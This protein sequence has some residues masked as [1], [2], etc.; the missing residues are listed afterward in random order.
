MS[1]LVIELQS[2]ITSPGCDIVNILRK[3]HLI[4][5]K[6]HLI[7]F[8]QWISYELNGY[9]N[10]KIIPS[11]RLVCGVLKALNPYR[12]WIP[13]MIS[14]PELEKSICEKKVPNSIS[15]IIDLCEQANTGLIFE[16]SGEQLEF[17]NKLFDAPLPMQYS[18][19]VPSSRVKDIVE[20]VKNTVLE[21]TI[22]LES[23][24]ILGEGMKFNDTEKK[25]AQHIPQTVNNYYGTTSVVNGS[26]QNMQIVSGSDDE[27]T[28]TY[29]KAKDAVEEI[30][31][32]ISND[33]ISDD[34]QKTALE[35]LSEIN[36]KIGQEK[37]PT[38][39]K[40]GLVGLKDFLINAGA[41]IAAGLIQ[42]KIQGMF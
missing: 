24:G 36:D 20:K 22:K 34:D 35:I 4:A 40:S 6:L 14:N 28:F 16:F 39:I 23:E 2:E 21:W 19:Y 10:Q 42:A 9:P 41:G 15:E 1:S 12:G 26:T 30:R 17:F 3:A 7:E 13:T 32:S 29:E 18:L 33:N 8:D 27:V 37:K 11:Y 31:A 25:S 38:I 5:A